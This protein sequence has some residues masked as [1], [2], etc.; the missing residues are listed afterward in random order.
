MKI[1]WDGIDRRI[2]K[3]TSVGGSVVMV[4]PS[5]DSKTYAFIASGADE[6]EGGSGAPALYTIAEDGSR[7]TRVSQAPAPDASGE[8]PRGRGFRGTRGGA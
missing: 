4:A 6:G 1:E 2:R 5:P 8:T 7:L 3:L